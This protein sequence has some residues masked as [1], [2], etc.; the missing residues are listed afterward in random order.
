MQTLF[1]DTETTG[2][3]PPNDKLVEIAIVDDGGDTILDTLIN[4]ERPKGFSVSTIKP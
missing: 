1:L 2:L 3:T 4:P